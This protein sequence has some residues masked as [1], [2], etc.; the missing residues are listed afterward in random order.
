M[1]FNFGKAFGIEYWVLS[2]KALSILMKSVKVVLRKLLFSKSLLYKYC[3]PVA[4]NPL[5]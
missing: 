4:K 1:A 3:E 2:I 5:K